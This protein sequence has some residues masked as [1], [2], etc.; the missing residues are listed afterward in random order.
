[1]PYPH[2]IQKTMLKQGIPGEIIEQFIFS[3]SIKLEC[4]PVFY[5][6]I[7]LNYPLSNNSRYTASAASPLKPP[8]VRA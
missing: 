4:F 1:M 5:L 8:G 6:N 3:D 7:H 2:K